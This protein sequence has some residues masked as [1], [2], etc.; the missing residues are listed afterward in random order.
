L[1]QVEIQ[2]NPLGGLPEGLA[3]FRINYIVYG[4]SAFEI[5]YDPT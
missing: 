2:A 5:I 3:F 1:L 4:G